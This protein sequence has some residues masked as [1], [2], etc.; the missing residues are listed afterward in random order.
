[1]LALTP[2][3]YRLL[4]ALVQRPEQVLARA[5]LLDAMH[6]DFRD[7]SDRTVDSH[8]KNLRRKLAAAGPGA[9]CIASV[10]GVGYRFEVPEKA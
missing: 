1:M 3:E 4:R 6:L 10:Y 9:D 7:T 2:V 5:Q 8:V